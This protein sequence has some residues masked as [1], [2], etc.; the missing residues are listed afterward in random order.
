MGEYDN[1]QEAKSY[2]SIDGRIRFM[3]GWAKSDFDLLVGLVVLFLFHIDGGGYMNIWF[4][5][6]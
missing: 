4:D 3:S 2:T 6:L 5:V 1:L